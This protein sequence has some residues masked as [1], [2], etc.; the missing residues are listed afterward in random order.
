M[1]QTQ[2]QLKTGCV[3]ETKLNALT[4]ELL[5]LSCSK[6]MRER[7][8]LKSNLEQKSNENPKAKFER[9]WE[10]VSEWEFSVRAQNSPLGLYLKSSSPGTTARRWTQRSLAI[11]KRWQGAIARW[12]RP[13]LGFGRQPCGPTGWQPGPRGSL[14]A[15]SFEILGAR[16]IFALKD[17]QNYFSKDF[18]AQIFFGFLW[19]EEKVLEKFLACMSVLKIQICSGKNRKSQ[20]K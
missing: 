8:L 3:S 1:E 20:K 13:T 16:P 15:I 17:V 9:V 4:R 19:K 12:G 11:G 5:L 2:V 6:E 10:G 7:R 14:T 18:H